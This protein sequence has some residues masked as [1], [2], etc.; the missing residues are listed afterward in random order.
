MGVYFVSEGKIYDNEYMMM[1]KYIY[2]NFLL[3]LCLTA[4]YS[5][6]SQTIVSMY[7][8]VESSRES[9]TN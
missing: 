8:K 6:K 3:H 2:L 9:Q 4:E 5:S 7:M 1:V